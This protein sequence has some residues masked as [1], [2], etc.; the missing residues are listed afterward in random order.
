[1]GLFDLFS[2]PPGEQEQAYTQGAATAPD[3]LS[4]SSNLVAE[5]LC[6][7]IGIVDRNAQ[8][9]LFY[10]VYALSALYVQT[11]MLGAKN[12]RIFD[13]ANGIFLKELYAGYDRNLIDAHFR[14]IRFNLDKELTK[15]NKG[16]PAFKHILKN[17][18][19]EILNGAN[20]KN[21]NEA[22][23]AKAIEA[24]LEITFKLTCDISNPILAAGLNISN[25]FK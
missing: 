16:L 9:N 6:K 20:I 13:K 25:G 15:G 11:C 24:T 23:I 7:A 17:E 2:N 14:S 19:L 12:A 3:A 10:L 4:E 22:D 8:K 1:M 21:T 18:I 5:F